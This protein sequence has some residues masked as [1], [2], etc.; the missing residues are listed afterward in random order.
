M[1]RAEPVVIENYDVEVKFVEELVASERSP[2]LRPKRRANIV[3]QHHERWSRPVKVAGILESVRGQARMYIGDDTVFVTSS[4]LRT[5]LHSD[6]THG[7]L[8]HLRG[9]KHVVFTDDMGNRRRSGAQADLFVGMH[10]EL[11][12]GDILFIPKRRL[13][14]VES[15]DATVSLSMRAVFNDDLARI[16]KFLSCRDEAARILSI[17]AAE[18]AH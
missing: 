5:P 13:H 10:A 15:E 3:S 14:D 4:G 11:T 18:E 17:L 8:V 6:E 9:R 12:P 16:A 7:L 2:V 1:R